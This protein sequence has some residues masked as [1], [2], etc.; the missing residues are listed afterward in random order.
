MSLTAPFSVM[1]SPSVRRKGV[2]FVRESPSVRVVPDRA[3]ALNV[4]A[5]LVTVSFVVSGA[6]SAVPSSTSTVIGFTSAA[7]PVGLSSRY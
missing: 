7:V 5:T 6:E 1:E 2:A 4:G 3:S